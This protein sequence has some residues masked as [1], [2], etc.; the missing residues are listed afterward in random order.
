MRGR[1]DRPRSLGWRWQNGIYPVFLT[2]SRSSFSFCSHIVYVI[3]DSYSRGVL[4]TLTPG[5]RSAGSWTP[6]ATVAF[7]SAPP[8][9]RETNDRFCNYYEPS[10]ELACLTAAEGRGFMPETVFRC[11]KCRGS[12]VRAVVTGG[13]K[14]TLRVNCFWKISTGTHTRCENKLLC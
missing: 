6:T 13:T 12:R 5:P 10:A 7:Q 2:G 11:V 4:R 8:L 1:S 14:R 9:N 3:R